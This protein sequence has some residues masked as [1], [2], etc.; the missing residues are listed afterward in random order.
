M[1]PQLNPQSF[2][3]IQNPN[4]F[5]VGWARATDSAQPTSCTS[6]GR[7]YVEACESSDRH[8]VA[9]ACAIP[10]RRGC[11]WIARLESNGDPVVVLLRLRRRCAEAGWRAQRRG[12]R[13]VAS[14][15]SQRAPASIKCSAC[16]PSPEVVAHL[17]PSP[18]LL[19][20]RARASEASRAVALHHLGYLKPPAS[21]SGF[22]SLTRSS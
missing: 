17:L 22:L 18:S 16:L 19:S 12:R 2:S 14:A 1:L 15:S 5:T 11:V 6:P 4:W 8:R 20:G 13:R 10:L 21:F 9:G 7:S 3:Q